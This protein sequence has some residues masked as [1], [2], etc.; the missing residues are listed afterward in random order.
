[1]KKILGGSWNCYAE[2][3]LRWIEIISVDPLHSSS[4]LSSEY[5]NLGWGNP[6][7]KQKSQKKTKTKGL[8][9]IIIWF[10]LLNS[11]KIL[12]NSKAFSML[13]ARNR[14]QDKHPRHWEALQTLNDSRSFN[15]P[16]MKFMQSSIH[17]LNERKK[18]NEKISQKKTIFYHHKHFSRGHVNII[19]LNGKWKK[20]WRNYYW[21]RKKKI[22]NEMK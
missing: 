14:L 3:G 7:D 17:S 13:S 8:T 18:K 20:C 12:L 1:M 2:S 11:R 9:L 4:E 6:D 10:S 22:S 5:G 16:A 19:F 21:Y 15:R